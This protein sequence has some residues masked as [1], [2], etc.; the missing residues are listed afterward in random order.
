MAETL[1][2]FP[3]VA[4]IDAVHE[5]H[6]LWLATKGKK[7]RRAHF[8]RID[9]SRMDLSGCRF[10]EA[11]MRGITIRNVNLSGADLR[12]CDMAETYLE[13]VDL[14][15]ALLAGATL[16]RARL[17]NVNL[18]GVDLA[19]A[20]LLGITTKDVTFSSAKLNRAV[21]RDAQLQN[22]DF[23]YA[24]LTEANLRGAQCNFA[25]F[26]HADLSYAECREANFEQ[27]EFSFANVKN[28]NFRNAVLKGIDLQLV[29]FSVAQEVTFDL[30]T[31]SLLA[32]RAKLAEEH[33]QMAGQLLQLEE[34]GRALIAE[35][36]RMDARESKLSMLEIRFIQ[37]RAALEWISQVFMGLSII[38]TALCA[39][40]VYLTSLRVT[41]LGYDNVSGIVLGVGVVLIL[42]FL[43]VYFAA[44][45]RSIIA[46][47]ANRGYPTTRKNNN[48]KHG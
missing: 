15:G 16:T 21:L 28:A 38:W 31:Q 10:A 14:S 22:T 35:K 48:N 17:M 30:H 1:F 36:E 4:D 34:M 8:R 27:A 37:S 41:E 42:S 33:K 44:K 45:T 12:G 18:E 26:E 13:N 43:S 46:F 11:S 5:E 24:V 25:H 32:E 7:G 47:T 19:E 9:I 6:A 23:S 40:L 3:P 29:D 39:F 20:N 2:L